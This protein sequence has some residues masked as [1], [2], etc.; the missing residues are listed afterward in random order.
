MAIIGQILLIFALNAFF[1]KCDNF[2]LDL[3][4]NAS[5]D[6]SK[7]VNITIYYI[8]GLECRKYGPTPHNRIVRVVDGSRNI[9]QG[10][11]AECTGAILYPSTGEGKLLHL[12][13]EKGNSFG[14]KYYTRDGDQWKEIR[15]VTYRT[16]LD[17]FAPKEL[18]SRD[19]AKPTGKKK[20][21]SSSV[22]SLICTLIVPALVF[23]NFH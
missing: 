13:L 17:E 15:L 6:S 19:P 4:P 22:P 21:G 8:D 1:C 2:T 20:A 12:F 3:S 23:T 16:H 7:R 5:S 18:Q 11:D 14:H 9:W 10:G